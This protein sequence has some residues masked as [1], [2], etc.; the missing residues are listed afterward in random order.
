MSTIRM[1]ARHLP[2][3]DSEALGRYIAAKGR[4]DQRAGATVPEQID[5]ALQR[6]HASMRSCEVMLKKLQAAAADVEQVQARVLPPLLC[7]WC[8]LIMHLAQLHQKL[9]RPAELGLLR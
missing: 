2:Q 9:H 1:P 6:L 3:A 8:L 5:Q 4:Q 7:V